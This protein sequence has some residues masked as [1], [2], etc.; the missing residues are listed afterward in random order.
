[1]TEG[2]PGY[3]ELHASSAFSFLRGASLPEDLAA[4]AGRLGLTAV[5]LCDRDGLYGAPRLYGAGREH[6][7]RALVGCELTL[8]DGSVLPLLVMNRGGYRNLCRLL[9][10]T[11]LEPRP[12]GLGHPDLAERK[13]P[14]YAAPEELEAV[15]DGLSALTGDTEGPVL[16][17]WRTGGADAAERALV[18]LLRVFGPDRVAVELQRHGLRGEDRAERLLVALAE[19]H[20]LP[21]VAT[22][23]VLFARE[24]GREIADVFACLRHHTTLDA[25]GRRLLANAGRRLASPAEMRR[26][27]ADRPDAL[28]NGRRLG[29]RLEFTLRDL[30]YRFPS[31][32][33]SSDET[34][35][36]CLRERTFAGARDRFP[37]FTPRHRAQLERELALI[38][39]LGFCGYF[40]IVQDI[41]RWARER[42]MLVQG[43][44]S[45]ANSAVCYALGITAV[46]PIAHRLLFERF[47]SEGRVGA[48]GHPSWP[49]IDLD[50]PSGDLRE[51][52][53]QEVYRR[54]APRGAAMTANV[55][56]YRGR[57][58]AR[59]LGGVLGLPEDAVDRFSSLFASGDYPHTVELE[60]Q[61]A[62]SGLDREHPRFPALIRLYGRLR[63]LPRHLGQ[64]SGGMVISGE[65]LDTVAPLEPAT[66]PGRV[67]IQWDKDD[68]EDLGIVKVD[69]LGL[70]MMAAMQESFS[71]LAASGGHSDLHLVPRE[72]PAT[73][74]AMCRADTVGVF[75]IESRAQMATLPR[76]RPRC[77]YDV[78]MQVAIVRPGPIVG[79][80]VH[81]LIRRRAG[82]EKDVYIDE[83][84]NELLQPVLE[85]TR[86]V[87]LFQEQMLA[88]AMKLAGF[89][90][91]E[92]EELRRAM[93]FQRSNERLRRVLVKLRAALE[94][95][96]HPPAVA[97][98]VVNTACSFALYGFPESHALSF[99][100][101]AYAST[102]L[103]VHRPAAFYTGLLNHQPMGFYS[104]ATLVQDARRH[105]VRILPVCVA[106]SDWGCTLEA[107]DAVRI[108][109]RYLQGLRHAAVEGLVAARQ[110]R[111]FSS[112]GDF[113]ART[114]FTAAERR[115][116]AAVGAL[117]VLTRHRRAALWQVEAAWS[118]EESLFHGSSAFAVEEDP[119][120]LAP[121]SA[122]ERVEADFA[123]LHLSTG[124][125]PMARV[126]D[127]LPEVWR[128]CDLPL[129]RDGEQ[130]TIAGTVI[131]RQRPGT[132]KGV[133]FISLEDETGIAN[134]IV[135]SQLF[136]QTRLVVNQ[137]PSLRIVGRLQHREGVIA[138]QA[139]AIS[140]LGLAEVPAQASHDFH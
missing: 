33:L 32:P 43:R 133:V 87:V 76:F 114:A 122:Q 108:G 15:A 51:S 136:E 60:R 104:P 53:I 119:S 29:E 56:T 7:V 79:Q 57:S 11:K 124:A 101:I 52:V 80:L 6:G 126:R 100:L 58:T 31:Y 73:F 1:M 93:G 92:A 62:L 35:E 25:A 45:A 70:G 24:D 115:A 40:L 110:E 118:P 4:E 129:G 46:D 84:L 95:R 109:L 28:D 27:F 55:I 49:D 128:A 14:S 26:R 135:R 127:R 50:L 96:G 131:C 140:A 112:L 72:D 67:V 66:M 68:C 9:T 16:H 90:G 86:G 39:K 41:C 2:D 71:L 97:E 111:P 44:G 99:A 107:P 22:G 37:E 75:Q 63:G 88:V 12:A 54:Y 10:R 69:L 8:A 82:Q 64:H 61:F 65:P 89:S 120:P 85:R 13:R 116:L 38:G 137:E 123:G 48:D 134:A 74:E 17:A 21:L 81:P 113:L 102:W 125:H 23:G 19:R 47:L 98:K 77:F 139:S 83:S 106:A 103:K 130:V 59:A 20:R 36:H 105:G 121:M 138:V 132:A 3:V 30:G 117:N 94:A 91:S 18:G 42:G 34:P 5:A 78:A